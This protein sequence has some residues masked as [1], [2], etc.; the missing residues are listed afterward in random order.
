[1]QAFRWVSDTAIFNCKKRASRGESKGEGEERRREKKKTFSPLPMH[2]LSPSFT[3]TP[4]PGA[5]IS[6]LSCLTNKIKPL[7]GGKHAQKPKLASMHFL[8][9]C[10]HLVLGNQ[11]LGTGTKW[12]CVH[13]LS[14]R[15][16]TVYITYSFRPIRRHFETCA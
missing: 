12:Y 6:T 11:C 10:P 4:T 1:M 9:A 15:Y 16:V 7:F 13:T 2:P 3:P 5:V 14:T 8:R